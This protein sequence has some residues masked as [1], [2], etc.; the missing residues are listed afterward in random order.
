MS[1]VVTRADGVVTVTLD[2]PEKRNAVTIAMWAQ[3]ESALADLREDDAVLVLT[4]SGGTFSSGSDVSEFLDPDYDIAAGIDSTHRVV[5]AVAALPIPSVAVVDGI[6][7]GSALNLALACDLVV[8]SDRATFCEIFA[9]RGLS[10]DSGASW[11]VPR[12]VGERRA[13]QLLLLADRL[14][15]ATALDWGLITAVVPT[16]QLGSEAERY[17]ERLRAVPPAA[18]RSIRELIAGTWSRP[19]SEALDAEAANQLTVLGAGRTQDLV[20]AFTNRRKDST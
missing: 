4:G 16:E 2:R 14:D 19:L 7:A 11:L 3:L 1:V 12:L 20:N 13:R 8:A 6:A 18:S 15:A 17:A 9:Q 10:V 5:A